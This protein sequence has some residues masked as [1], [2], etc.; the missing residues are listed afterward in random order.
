MMDERGLADVRLLRRSLLVKQ[1]EWWRRWR[2][3]VLLLIAA[4]WFPVLLLAIATAW[5]ALDA[6]VF[7]H[8]GGG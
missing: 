5:N 3:P 2:W 1:Q 4:V 8:G 7:G 6:L